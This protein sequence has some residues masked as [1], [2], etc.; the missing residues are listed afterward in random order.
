[1]ES[2]ILEKLVRE[3]SRKELNQG[4]IFLLH[5]YGSNMNDLFSFADSL[6]DDQYVISLNAPYETPLGGNAWYSLNYDNEGIRYDIDDV[7]KVKKIIENNIR[8]TIKDYGLDSQ[9]ITLIGFSQGAILSY[10]LAADFPGMIKHIIAFSGYLLDEY[11]TDLKYVQLSKVN[12]FIS[13]G[14]YDEIIPLKAARDTR[15]ILQQNNVE[16]FYKEYEMPH[17]VSPECLDDALNWYNNIKSK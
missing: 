6:P 3:P 15:D 12:I 9:K 10:M 1:M 11:K 16:I 4:G 8:K 2:I 17:G 14:K 5:G 13:H 7:K